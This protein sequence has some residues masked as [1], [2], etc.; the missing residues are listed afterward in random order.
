MGDADE[1]LLFWLLLLEKM[2]KAIA[3]DLDG[4]LI[5]VSRRD[6][7]IYSDLVIRLGG[8]PLSYSEYWP[9]RQAK[10]DIHQILADSGIISNDQVSE[11][12]A[13]RRFLM[14]SSE[15]LAI[16]KMFPGTLEVL[17]SLSQNFEIH[18]LTIRHNR[19]N[20]E[21]Q[22]HVLKLDKYHYHIVDGNK[23]YTMLQIPNL[24][25]M[26]GDTENDILPANNIGIKSVAVTTGIR[27]REL[28]LEMN[29]TYILEGLSKIS[30]IVH[31]RE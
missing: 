24:C 23:E 8:M 6:Y 11:F 14:E 10:T 20:T 16:D 18:I 21:N 7:Q 31:G 4:T 30:N 12:L 2:K 29:P 5:D 1:T 26:V 19:I 3:F 25:F 22:L 17:N 27:N 13:E 28:L 15:Y 9:L